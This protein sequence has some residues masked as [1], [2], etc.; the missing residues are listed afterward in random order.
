[1]TP[2]DR[3]SVN[4]FVT[5]AEKCENK[6]QILD[7]CEKA[8]KKYRPITYQKREDYKQFMN[9]PLPSQI[10][11][12]Q[13]PTYIVKAGMVVDA[14]GAGRMSATE[15]NDR[16]NCIYRDLSRALADEVVRNKLVKIT[17]ELRQDRYEHTYNAS[18]E[19]IVP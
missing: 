6:E 15:F 17:Q 7:L 3:I 19:V 11:N 5:L 16:E 14:L 18:M 1:M 9:N 12:D 2:E 4:K 13:R 8:I 10:R